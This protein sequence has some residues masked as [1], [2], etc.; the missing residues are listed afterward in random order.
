MDTVHFT[1]ATEEQLRASYLPESFIQQELERRRKEELANRVPEYVS[2]NGSESEKLV[3]D[4]MTA[5]A[6]TIVEIMEFTGLGRNAVIKYR[7]RVLGVPVGKQLP[8][9]PRKWGA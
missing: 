1:E 7:H 4:A 6:K 8:T 9:D 3:I 5:G 2:G